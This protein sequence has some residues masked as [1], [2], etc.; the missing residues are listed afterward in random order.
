MIVDRERGRTD[1]DWIP[2]RLGGGA[3][4]SRYSRKEKEE[5]KKI[6]RKFKDKIEGKST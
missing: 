1:K 4:R 6:I 2:M 3:G 5:R